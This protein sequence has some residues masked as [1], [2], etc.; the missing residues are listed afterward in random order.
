MGSGMA[1][2]LL[3]KGYKVFVYDINEKQ[4]ESLKVQGALCGDSPQD[5][6]SQSNITFLSL[7]TPEIVVEVINGKSGVLSGSK[8]GDVIVDLSTTDPNTIRSL[9]QISKEKGVSLLDAPVS[10]GVKG[11]KE[12]TLA[13]MVGGEEEIFKKIRP[14]LECFGKNIFYAGEVGNG[15]SAKLIGQYLNAVNLAAV[16]EGLVLGCKLGLE[17]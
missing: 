13:I 8:E 14:I 16:C 9:Y 1:S 5:V 15:A 12:G 17:P 10:G 11:A 3:K 4:V 7:P 2:N 6:S